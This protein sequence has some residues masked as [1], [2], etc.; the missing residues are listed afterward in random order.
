MI[1]LTSKEVSMHGFSFEMSMGG[2]DVL[3][4]G[5]GFG[6]IDKDGFFMNIG[7]TVISDFVRI[8]VDDLRYLATEILELRAK[9]QLRAKY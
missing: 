1:L 5:K 2:Y 7:V 9:C 6:A 4:N 3:Y 8:S